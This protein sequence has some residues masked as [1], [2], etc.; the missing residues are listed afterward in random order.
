MVAF[1]KNRVFPAPPEAAWRLLERR[2]DDT[3]IHAIHPLALSQTTVPRIGVGS[4]LE[5]TIDLRGRPIRP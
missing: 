4:I 2:F 5:R 1:E 3:P